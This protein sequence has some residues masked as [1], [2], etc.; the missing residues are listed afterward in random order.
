VA[1]VSGSFRADESFFGL[2]I[3]KAQSNLSKGEGGNA[4]ASRFRKE[5]LERKRLPGFFRLP[6]L[7]KKPKAKS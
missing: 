5:A 3:S 4:R 7:S 1:A 6:C 2:L